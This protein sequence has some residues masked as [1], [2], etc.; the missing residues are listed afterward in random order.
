MTRT[1][2]PGFEIQHR[3]ANDGDAGPI[4]FDK[5]LRTVDAVI[6][7]GSPVKR[8]YG[9]EVLRIDPQSVIIDRLV[10]GGIPLLNSHNQG[11]ITAALGKVT[12]V[13]FS[14]DG[15]LMGKL[16]FND[17]AE[18]RKAGGMVERGEIAGISAGY[19]VEEWEISDAEGRIVDEDQVGWDDDLTFT[20]TRWELI[21]ASL[22]STPADNSASIRSLGGGNRVSDTRA[23]MMARQRMTIRQAMSDRQSVMFG[24]HDD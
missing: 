17:T 9:V 12:R 15:A 1:G 7:R 11:D 20:A 14:D 23:R 19:R 21:E 10:G 16:K 3:F 24:D 8:F 18:G 22:V 4:T 13:W 2:P 6:S 5:Q